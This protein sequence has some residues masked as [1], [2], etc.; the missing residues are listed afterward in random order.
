[1]LVVLKAMSH[2]RDHKLSERC[3]TRLGRPSDIARITRRGAYVYGGMFSII[4]CLFVFVFEIYIYYTYVP[5]TPRIDGGAGT[6]GRVTG[7]EDPKKDKEAKCSIIILHK[8]LTRRLQ[9]FS[10][11]QIRAIRVRGGGVAV[12]G[13]PRNFARTVR[14]H[15]CA[16]HWYTLLFVRR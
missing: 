7:V 16:A 11:C 3:G 6:H 8:Q 5:S 12:V 13:P 4:N 14:R 10:A 9:Y 1:M 2:N 15:G